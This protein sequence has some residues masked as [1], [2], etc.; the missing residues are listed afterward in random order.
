MFRMFLNKQIQS[1]HISHLGLHEFDN[2]LEKHRL[3]DL[4]PNRLISQ[5]SSDDRFPSIHVS[6]NNSSN[7][8]MISD[9]NNRNRHA[10]PSRDSLH[11]DQ[12]FPHSSSDRFQ[13]KYQQTFTKIQSV[14][15]HWHHEFHSFFIWT[16]S[17]N[18]HIIS[19]TR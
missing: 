8:G 15:T 9:K 1:L 11:S 4:N 3:R 18:V 10:D 17:K 16:N 6:M 14:A 19:H 5:V 12:I 2:R 13:T 7:V